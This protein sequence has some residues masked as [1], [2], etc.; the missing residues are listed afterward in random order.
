VGLLV[1]EDNPGIGLAGQ[2]PTEMEHGQWILVVL[3]T[4]ACT[5]FQIR[6]KA[7]FMIRARGS[8]TMNST[9]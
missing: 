7:Q 6:P 5:M 2:E 1:L 8:G 3:S 9:P 4:Y